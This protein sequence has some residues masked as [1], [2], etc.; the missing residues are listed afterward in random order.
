MSQK[1]LKAI[2]VAVQANAPILTVGGPGIGKTSG[3]ISL[4]RQLSMPYEIVI[5]S[6]R[7]PADFAGLPVVTDGGVTLAAP[8]WAK[9][10]ADA[11]EGLLFLDE[12]STAA[13][14][15]QAALLRVVLD[16]VVGDLPLPDG[17]RIVAAMNPADQA[18]GGWELSPPLS[19]RFCHIPWGLNVG[20]WVD[21][22]MQGFPDVSFPKLPIGW[23]DRERES[24]LLVASFVQH[25]QTILYNCPK[26]DSDAGKPWPSPRSWTM[27]AKLAAAC[28][29]AGTTQEVELPLIAGCVGDG[30]ALEFVNWRD[31]L[32]LPDPEKLLADP[33]LFV[34]PERGD[35]AYTILASVASAAVNN[36]TKP[37]F[38]AAWEIFKMAAD[39]GK[40]DL[41]AAAVRSLAA[42]ATKQGYMG[43]AKVK[44]QIV[45]NIAPFVQILKQAGLF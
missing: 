29:A 4:A 31:A 35:K 44:A 12:I 5:A 25:K 36:M 10:L 3:I 24:R 2:A 18:A 16:R 45:A 32:D 17:I 37:R 39:A 42:A 6:L 40:K 7:E 34:V 8:S 9:R 22:M 28:K 38:L 33:K 23:E 19:N 1:A 15:V 27:A 20:E 11:G 13:P 26:N 14:A 43:D 30:P 21:G 41:A